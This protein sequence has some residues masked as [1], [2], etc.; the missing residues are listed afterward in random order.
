[1]IGNVS[2]FCAGFY[3]PQEY[4]TYSGSKPVDD[5]RGP[6][7]GKVRVRRGG[8]Y[9]VPPT[10]CTPSARFEARSAD[11]LGLSD[12]GFRVARDAGR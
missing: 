4:S 2:E 5:P 11:L 6:E 3:D 7:T 12:T 10:R 1:M 9:E 8:S